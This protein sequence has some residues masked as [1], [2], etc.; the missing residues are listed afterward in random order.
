M[1]ITV[2]ALF[3]DGRGCY[4]G[5]PGVDPWPIERDA[6]DYAGP[7]P[8]VAHPP[9]KRWGRFWHG[10]TRRPHQFTLGADSGCFATALTAVRTWGGVLEHPADSHAWDFFGLGK[11]VRGS[12]TVSITESGYSDRIAVTAAT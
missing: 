11:P 6:R 9:C 7:L 4:A 2:A 12:V 10:S 5:L 8:V 3:V 1:T